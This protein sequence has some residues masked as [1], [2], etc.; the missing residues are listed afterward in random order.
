MPPRYPQG[1]FWLLTIKKDIWTPYEELNL[2][3]SVAY[4]KGQLELGEGGY[5]HW[6][7]LVSFKRRV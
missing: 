3:D 6:Q 2:P 4:C 1:R 5:E 7:V